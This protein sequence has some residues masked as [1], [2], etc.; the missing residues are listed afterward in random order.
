MR[1]LFDHLVYNAIA[2]LNI[3]AKDWDKIYWKFK[4]HLKTKTVLITYQKPTA[5]TDYK[6]NIINL[7]TENKCIF[8]PIDDVKKDA[9]NI[10]AL[11]LSV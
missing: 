8:T 7:N 4:M 2:L 9:K 10:A 5:T 11:V 1:K 6:I 3:V